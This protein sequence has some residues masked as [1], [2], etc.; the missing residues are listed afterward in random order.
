MSTY[1]GLICRDCGVMS[2]CGARHSW[3]PELVALARHAQDIKTMLD[4]P[5]YRDAYGL[6]EISAPTWWEET[7]GDDEPRLLPFLYEHAGHDIGLYDEYGNDH[8][9][10]EADEP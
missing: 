10:A 7:T 4:L 6:V 2:A 1:Y 9:L 8:P 5:V 3:R